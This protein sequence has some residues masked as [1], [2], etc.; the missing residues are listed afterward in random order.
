MGFLCDIWSIFL[1]GAEAINL[2]VII[3]LVRAYSETF[4]PD[5][6]AATR[7]ILLA[8]WLQGIVWRSC[9]SAGQITLVNFLLSRTGNPITIIKFI[10]VKCQVSDN[11]PATLLIG[12][13]MTHLKLSLAIL[14]FHALITV[15]N[16]VCAVKIMVI[17]SAN[18]YCFSKVKSL[19]FYYP[20]II[21]NF[22]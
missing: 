9:E 5:L 10:F 11:F 3:T 4:I 16:N 22:Y 13:M 14:P 6:F 19:H 2:L 1:V 18:L 17:D 15:L 21:I 12:G 8:V 7:P 20:L